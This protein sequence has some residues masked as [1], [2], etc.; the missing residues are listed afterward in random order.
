MIII[1]LF[2][3]LLFIILLIS[4]K[5]YVSSLKKNIHH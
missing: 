4:N 5:Y 2:I 1:Y 3:Q